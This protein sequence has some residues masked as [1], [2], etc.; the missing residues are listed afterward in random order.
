MKRERIGAVVLAAGAASRMG[1]P[2]QL[3]PFEG[4]SLVR[5]AA[6]AAI[7]AGCEPV[8]VVTGSHA[9]EVLQALVDLPVL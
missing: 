4:A 8:V 6:Q 5:R 7:A 2:K 3:L 9:K 1:A